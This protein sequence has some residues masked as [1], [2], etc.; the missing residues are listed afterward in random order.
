MVH[1]IQHVPIKKQVLF[2]FYGIRA[3]HSSITTI[4]HMFARAAHAQCWADGGPT[5]MTLGL[6]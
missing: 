5:S 1:L 3:V 4:A 2:E 6:H